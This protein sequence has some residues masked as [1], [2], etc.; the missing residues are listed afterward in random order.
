M[1]ACWLVLG[2]FVFTWCV[3]ECCGQDCSTHVVCGLTFVLGW[4]VWGSLWRGL[5]GFGF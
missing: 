2:N 5:V 1:T 4:K 3:A